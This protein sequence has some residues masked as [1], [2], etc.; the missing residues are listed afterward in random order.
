MLRCTRHGRKPNTNWLDGRVLPSRDSIY[1]LFFSFD[2]TP[3][4]ARRRHRLRNDERR[5]SAGGGAYSKFVSAKN[6]IARKPFFF[7]FLFCSVA[8][9]RRVAVEN[10]YRK[11]DEKRRRYSFGNQRA[12]GIIERYSFSRRS[13]KGRRLDRERLKNTIY[14]RTGDYVRYHWTRRVPKNRVF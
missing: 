13:P 4:K 11:P 3:K 10:R 7:L 6:E 1:F 14:T 8:N 2:E 12:Y 5:A 9:E